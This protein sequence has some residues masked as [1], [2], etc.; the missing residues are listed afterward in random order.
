MRRA[1]TRGYPLVTEGAGW[2]RSAHDEGHDFE[3]VDKVWNE[4]GGYWDI[5]LRD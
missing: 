3:V 2:G 4:A 1:E 5:Y